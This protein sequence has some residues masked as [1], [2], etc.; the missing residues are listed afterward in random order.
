[1]SQPILEDHWKFLC[2]K[3]LILRLHDQPEELPKKRFSGS[4][5][6]LQSQRFKERQ[7]LK[8]EGRRKGWLGY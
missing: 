6:D 2:E 7:K 3:P 5:T 1:M 4:M 8:E